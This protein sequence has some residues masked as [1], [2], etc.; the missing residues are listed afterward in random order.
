SLLALPLVITAAPLESLD[1]KAAE[2]KL[3]GISE[4]SQNYIAIVIF[5]IAL[6]TT[7]CTFT[8]FSVM[9]STLSNI[10]KFFTAAQGKMRAIFGKD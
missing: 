6:L 10:N 7:I 4:N 5:F 9:K 3:N 2:R 8:I 1:E